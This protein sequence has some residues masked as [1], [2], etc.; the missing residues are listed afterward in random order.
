MNRLLRIGFKCKLAAMRS[1]QNNLYAFMCRG[2]NLVYLVGC[3]LLCLLCI[4]ASCSF[5]TDGLSATYSNYIC[6]TEIWH[7]PPTSAV[8]VVF[9]PNDVEIKGPSQYPQIKKYVKQ[10]DLWKPSP[11]PYQPYYDDS[12]VI[13]NIGFDKLKGSFLIMTGRSDWSIE[14]KDFLRITLRKDIENFYV[15]YDSRATPKP[16]WLTQDY[17]K[18]TKPGSQEPYTITLS[19]LDYTISPAKNFVKLEIWYRKVTPQT[20]EVVK[21]PGNNY[22]NPG[23]PKMTTGTPA[24]Y[25]I[26]IKPKTESN[27]G[28]LGKHVYTLGSVPCLWSRETAEDKKNAE[29]E[30]EKTCESGITEPGAVCRNSTCTYKGGC[31]EVTVLYGSAL[32]SYPYSSEIGFV[33][34]SK[35]EITIQGQGNKFIRRV[36]GTLHF[37]Y[38]LN[39]GDLQIDSMSLDVESVGTEL[40]TFEDIFVLLRNPLKAACQSPLLIFS[41]PCTVYQIPKGDFKAS[42]S[43]KLNGQTIV[44]LAENTQVI[45]IT[46][47]HTKRSFQFTGSLQTIIKIDDQD[48]P[49]DIAIDLYGYFV[50]FAPIAK[51][52][53]STKFTECTENKNAQPIILNAA[54]SFD[55]YDPNPSNLPRYEWYE[56]YGLITEY[57]WGNQSKVT[58]APHTLSY[59]V[60]SMTLLVADKDGVVDTD[61]FDV[62]VGDKLPPELIV[63]KDIT[64]TTYIPGTSMRV[65]IGEA[66]AHDR[67]SGKVMSTND[68]PENLLFPPGATMVT[69]QADDNRGNITTAVQKVTVQFSPLL[70]PILVTVVLAALASGFLMKYFRKKK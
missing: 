56:D 39:T 42:V 27:C 43:V 17:E 24:M 28:T 37:Q 34:P 19:M 52:I 40:G 38:L 15:A 35:A 26:L 14:E 50:N 1:V 70:I 12:T 5:N 59:G 64:V 47:D 29:A 60:H 44:W 10:P 69:W 23:W 3:L 18:M 25:I 57:L 13:G 41:Q 16:D 32:K 67:C 63:P 11:Q 53:E 66:S 36:N 54:G 45:A 61:T 22:G 6:E 46:I 30:A 9:E 2:K 65:N 58:I 31:P 33:D 49:V 51:G 62:V 8:N 20:G 7:C 48:T 55:I 21:I 68:A 4:Q